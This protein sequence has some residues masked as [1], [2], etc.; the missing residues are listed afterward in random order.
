MRQTWRDKNDVQR[1]LIKALDC[2]VDKLRD[3]NGK[4]GQPVRQ[5]KYVESLEED[6]EEKA[7]VLQVYY[8][9]S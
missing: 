5:L 3:V 7:E 6:L 1:E 2:C 9:E 4:Q 8:E